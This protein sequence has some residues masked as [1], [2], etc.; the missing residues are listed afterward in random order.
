MQRLTES[1]KWQDELIA[2]SKSIAMYPAF[3]GVVVLSVLVFMMLYVVPEMV[4]FIKGMG[5]E[6]PFHTLALIGLSN[7]LVGNWYWAI[8]CHLSSCCRYV[9]R[10]V[11]ASRCVLLLMAGNSGCGT[12]DPLSIN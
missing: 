11:A 1:L 9:F 8:R 6:L 4:G 7:F 2:K 12:S 5:Q 10:H 3:V